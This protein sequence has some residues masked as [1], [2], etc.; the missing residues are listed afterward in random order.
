MRKMKTKGVLIFVVITIIAATL[1]LA[2]CGGGDNPKALA[3]QAAELFS[4]WDGD[5]P[6]IEKQLEAI[7]EKVEKL[8]E[9]DLKIYQ[10]EFDR[11]YDDD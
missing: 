4:K 3:K 10:E 9:A 5:D 6:A 8:S 11:L 1:V 2:G 7:A